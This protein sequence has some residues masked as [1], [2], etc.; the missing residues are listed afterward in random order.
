MGKKKVRYIGP[1][2]VIEIAETGEF[3]E[4]GSTIELDSV[5][6]DGL[7][8]QGSE[9]SYEGDGEDRKRVVKRLDGAPWELVRPRKKG[10]SK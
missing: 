2:A 1:A 10:A 6:A 8:E 9:I 4:R 5:L 7:L 3:V